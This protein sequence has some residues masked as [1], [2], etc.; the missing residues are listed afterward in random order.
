MAS[1][2]RVV[3]FNNSECV[4]Y[5]ILLHYC[6]QHFYVF[7][8]IFKLIYTSMSMIQKTIKSIVLSQF[9]YVCMIYVYLFIYVDR[10]NNAH[11]MSHC[12]TNTMQVEFSMMEIYNERIR[13]LLNFTTDNKQSKLKVRTH[14][15]TGVYCLTPPLARHAHTNSLVSLIYTRSYFLSLPAHND[16]VFFFCITYT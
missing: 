9:C 7:I 5:P 8:I 10:D 11:A 12:N 13:D 4:S 16:R 15:K 6:C 2:R 3:D 1:L 14:P